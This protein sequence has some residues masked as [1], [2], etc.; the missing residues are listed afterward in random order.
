[1]KILGFEIVRA[2]SEER[3]SVENPSVPLSQATVGELWGSSPTLSSV[4]VTEETAINFAAVWC[5]TNLLS[6]AVATLPLR[7]YE[8]DGTERNV[9]ESHP[10][11]ESLNNPNGMSAPDVY[12]EMAQNHVC[13]WGNHYSE[14]YRDGPGFRLE[15]VRPGQVTPNVAGPRG[16]KRIVYHNSDP[17]TGLRTVEAENMLHVP[18]LSFDGMRGLSPVR[19]LRESIGLGMAAEKFGAKFFGSGAR[20]SGVLQVPGNL[21]DKAYGRLKSEMKNK[22]GVENSHETLI[23]EEGITY[24]PTTIPPDD[25]QFLQTRKLQIEDIARMFLV[26]PHML[27][28][29]DNATFSNIEH[30]SIDF[31]VNTLRP[32][33]VKWENELNRKLLT[34]QE[35]SRYYFHFSVDALLRGDIK[36][37]YDAYAIGRQW[38]WLSAND[39]RAFEEMNP[40]DGGDVYMTPLNM[41]DANDPPD[42]GDDVRAAAARRQARRELKA[43]QKTLKTRNGTEFDMWLD[44]FIEDQVEIISDNLCL[45]NPDQAASAVRDLLRLPDI[46]GRYERA[47]TNQL[48]GYC[49]E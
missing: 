40:I 14:I 24:K 47:R 19:V 18:S 8:K 12:R 23:F 4:S 15:P 5:A 22:G 25:A 17:G 41:I 26:P 7:M 16:R 44:G 31:V 9:V 42:N 21:S 36:A 35:Q 49:Y 48:I 39:I 20:S 1:M 37:R 6:R 46:L 34:E 11:I 3:A 10:A 28:A 27:A 38:G 2:R 13:L 45:K 33:L 32:W 43:I 29:L 30:Q